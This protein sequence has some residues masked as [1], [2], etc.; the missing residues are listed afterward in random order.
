MTYRQWHPVRPWARRPAAIRCP[1]RLALPA[2]LP[3]LP[4]SPPLLALRQPRQPLLLT[5]RRHRLR[6]MHQLQPLQTRLRLQ[7]RRRHH[8]RRLQ[9]LPQPRPSRNSPSAVFQSNLW[10]PQVRIL[11][12]GIERSPEIVPSHTAAAGSSGVDSISCRVYA[13]LGRAHTSSASPV[14][15]SRPAC[16]TA[17]R[18]LK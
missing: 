7:P 3:P 17:I 18:V 12:P 2:T 16:I 10:V 11:G 6:P 8:R 14:S 13:S 4:A 1:V 9:P 15:T 5:L